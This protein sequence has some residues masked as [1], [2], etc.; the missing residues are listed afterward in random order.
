MRGVYTAT[1]Q[2]VAATAA[3][4]LFEISAESGTIVEILSAFIGQS[5]DYGDANAE[6]LRVSI[7]RLSASGTAVNT[8]TPRPHDSLDEAFGGVVESNNT[9]RGTLGVAIMEEVFNIQAGWYY[10]PTPEE[11]IRSA[12][13]GIL[14]IGL[15]S[16]PTDSVTL[17]GRVTF[18]VIG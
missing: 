11:R 15:E 13:G 4:S 17:S 2:G 12:A 16:A 9:T 8:L 1:F 14:E 3:Q 5:T 18:Q 10:T 7:N 6:G